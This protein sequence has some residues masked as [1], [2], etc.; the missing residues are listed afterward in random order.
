MGKTFRD[1]ERCLPRPSK[2]REHGLFPQKLDQE[3]TC[4]TMEH[5]E[6]KGVLQLS[7]EI[8]MFEP[9]KRPAQF[10][11]KPSAPGHESMFSYKH[12]ILI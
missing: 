12:N 5:K 11:R 2:N 6:G 3:T 4:S 8:T 9:N 1:L 10:N 7:L